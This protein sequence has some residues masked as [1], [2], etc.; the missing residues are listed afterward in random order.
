MYRRYPRII[1]YR[2]FLS[3]LVG[4]CGFHINYARTFVTLLSLLRSV[5]FPLSP[6][7]LVPDYMKQELL[8]LLKSTYFDS[9]FF[10]GSLCFI[11][12]AYCLL[13]CFSSL[14]ALC[15]TFL[16]SLECS[17]LIVP[18]VFSNVY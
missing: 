9:G 14:C 2:F 13:F 10:V 12:L 1:S 8:I 15:L 3:S 11:F 4:Y 7:K 16:V 5:F 17:F 6:T 18:S